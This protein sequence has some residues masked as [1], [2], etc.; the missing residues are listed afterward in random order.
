VPLGFDLSVGTFGTSELEVEEVWNLETSLAL[1]VLVAFEIFG[2]I[3]V[4]LE[5]VECG[6]D[7]LDVE[8]DVGG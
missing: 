5:L 8:L 2:L 1:S 4:A 6:R 3:C 7:G